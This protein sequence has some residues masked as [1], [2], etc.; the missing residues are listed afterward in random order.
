LLA[1]L[2]SSWVRVRAALNEI[3]RLIG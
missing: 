1:E 3:H 2:P